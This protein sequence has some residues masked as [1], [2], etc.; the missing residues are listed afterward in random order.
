MTS[1]GEPP[2]AYTTGTPAVLDRGAA[3]WAHR[4]V[5]NLA[6]IRYRDMI[7]DIRQASQA[8]EDKGAKVVASLVAA[9]GRANGGATPQQIRQALLGHAA[10]VLAATWQLADDLMVKFADGQRTTPQPDGSAVCEQLGYPE[11]W[12]RNADV[13]YTKGPKRLPPPA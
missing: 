12:L 11:D 2:K 10:D 9:Q 8:L 5:Q 13:N 1:M 6:Q 7:V 4:Y 3:Y